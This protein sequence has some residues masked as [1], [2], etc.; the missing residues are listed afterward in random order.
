MSDAMLEAARKAFGEALERVRE[1]QDSAALREA[2]VAALGRKS[3]LTEIKRSLGGLAEADRRE[4]GRFLNDA[5]EQLESAIAERRRALDVAAEEGLL[6]RDRVDVTL[7]GR[8]TPPGHPHPVT[9]MLDRIVDVFIGLGYR[10]AEGPEVETDW[11]N[12]EALNMPPD[13]PARSLWDTMYVAD[14]DET[15]V[16]R[17]H[18][19]PVQIRTMQSQ[20][21][22]VFIVAPGRCFRRDAFDPSHSPVFHQIEG[23]AVDRGVTFADLKGTIEAFAKAIFGPGARTRFR[24]S[25]FPFTEPSAEVDVTCTTCEGVGCAACSGSGWI[26]IMGAGMVHPALYRAVGYDP[27]A[28]SGFAFGMGVERIAMRAFG[29]SDIR[30]LWENDVRFLSQFAG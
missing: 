5:R 6:E 20:P 2:E 28:V 10:V 8:G 25:Y 17:T 30:T 19:S 14:G 29:V 13:H 12:F 7:P 9:L 16:L 27:E 24:P 15:V 18:T 21:P 11:Y 23:L 22:P 3:S 1:S 26:E 4:V